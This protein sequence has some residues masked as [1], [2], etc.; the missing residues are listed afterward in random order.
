MLVK[1]GEMAMSCHVE[2]GWVESGHMENPR[3]NALP[4]GLLFDSPV[5]SWSTGV[6]AT[7]SYVWD[8]EY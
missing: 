2:V 3:N 7:W 5:Y 8:L 1:F 4:S 6:S